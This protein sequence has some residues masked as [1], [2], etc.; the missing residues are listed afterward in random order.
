MK[1]LE[2]LRQSKD[3]LGFSSV[4]THKFVDYL[5]EQ[6][7]LNLAN[8]TASN[9]NFK[10]YGSNQRI[11]FEAV[12]KIIAEIF[13]DISDL[14]D[15][16]SFSEIRPEFISVKL[17]DLIFEDANIPN[18]ADTE[19]LRNLCSEVIHSLLL[20]STENSIVKALESTKD[21]DL[22]ELRRVSQ[23]ITSV[24]SSTIRYTGN[25]QDDT[26]LKHRHLVSARSNGLGS[27]SAPIGQ[28]WGDDLHYHEVVNGVVQPYEGHTHSVELGISTDTL[29]E[30]ENLRKVLKT[31]KPAHIKIGEISSVLEEIITKPSNSTINYESPSKDIIAPITEE[32]FIFSLGMSHQENMRKVRTGTWEN[33]LIGYYKERKIRIT[34]TLIDILDRVSIGGKRRKI[35]IISNLLIPSDGVAVE[36]QILRQDR[37]VNIDITNGIISVDET[38]GDNEIYV[39]AGEAFF[40]QRRARG[41]ALL[42]AIELD[43]D[44]PVDVATGL[45]EITFLEYT[46]KTTPLKKRS[47][48]VKVKGNGGFF[49]SELNAPQRRRYKGLPLLKEDF[50]VDGQYTLLEYYPYFKSI[51]GSNKISLKFASN[52]L[53]EGQEIEVFTPLGEDDLINFVDLNSELFVLNS[54]R[55]C[56]RSKAQ[57]NT[58][59]AIRLRSNAKSSPTIGLLPTLPVEPENTEIFKAEG[60]MQGSVGL[61]TVA[62]TLPEKDP[63]SNN[64]RNSN[65]NF[66]LNKLNSVSTNISEVRDYAVKSTKIKSNFIS[67]YELGF[68]PDHIIH[69][70]DSSGNLYDSEIMVNGI[71]FKDLSEDIEVEIKTISKHPY[72]R[73]DWSKGDI[74]SEGQV[75][76]EIPYKPLERKT[77]TPYE[78]MRNPTGREQDTEFDSDNQRLDLYTKEIK[79]KGI[80]AEEIFFE[81]D[82]TRIEI[83]GQP[84]F[85][86]IKAVKDIRRTIRPSLF[87][88]DQSIPLSIENKHRIGIRSILNRREVSEN[89]SL[90]FKIIPKADID[91]LA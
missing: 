23:H 19:N 85:R 47:I 14:Q 27:T 76:F 56:R 44:S 54:A 36:A 5:V 61:N 39:I 16:A 1:F 26:T 15:D 4:E 31:T 80:E 2:D 49:Y 43:L 55:S 40:A 21:G 10:N 91:A 34:E 59:Q 66:T 75:P 65:L 8:A 6:V 73:S 45:Q 37:T 30:Q 79:Q 70:K 48:T 82:W 13:L 53:T 69:V 84:Y 64:F 83:T 38:I 60:V 50:T 42:K 87:L 29:N 3:P 41:V 46:W 57:E 81:D 25:P 72:N 58:S 88:I 89:G 33:T 24:F 68:K 7:T 17:L 35:S 78:Q 63:N 62:Q 71:S 86:P 11:I 74:L 18:I 22:I 77:Y 9:Y 52:N 67:F 28:N 51:A 12:A 32:D 90:R 20:G